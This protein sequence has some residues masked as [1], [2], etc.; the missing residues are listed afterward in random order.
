MEEWRDIMNKIE[1]K[2][3]NKYKRKLFFAIGNR[4]Q[5]V[6]IDRGSFVWTHNNKGE[7]LIYDFQ[8]IADSSIKCKVQKNDPY[9]SITITFYS[10]S[11]G[12]E[13][14]KGEG[15][16]ILGAWYRYNDNFSE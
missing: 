15:D 1:R 5:P 12:N 11:R 14:V 2:F 4:F 13:I 16:T 9:D 8:M 6:N 10:Y 3:I 7:R